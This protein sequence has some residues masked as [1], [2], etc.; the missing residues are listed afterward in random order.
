MKLVVVS[1]FVDPLSVGEPRWCYDLAKA[2][3]EAVDTVVI[4]QS[5]ARAGACV[6]DFLPKAEVFE[7]SAW[8]LR[9]VPMRLNALIKPNYVKFYGFAR[10]VIER[11]LDRQAIACAHQFG[12]LGLR[13]PSP[14]R[15]SGIPY[16]IGPV[17]G[18][19]QTPPGFSPR[20]KREPW[21]YKL[22]DVDGLRFRHDPW[23]R[24]TYANADVV[25]GT[26]DY[27]HDV[28][29]DIELRSFAT[30]SEIAAMPPPDDID[31]VLAARATQQGPLR[32]LVVSRLV[33]TKGVQFTL[34]ALAA[35]QGRL[36]DW[37]LDVLGDGVYR[38]EL[39]RLA[40][41]LGIAGRVRFHGHVKR[42]EVDG[43]YRAANVFLF[44]SVREPSGAVIF[45]AMS[46]GLPQIVADYGGPAAHVDATLGIRVPVDSPDA[47][48][49]RLADAIVALGSAPERR[50]AM[51]LAALDAARNRHGMPAMVRFFLG[52][53]EQI[54]RGT[55]SP[56]GG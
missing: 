42:V 43:Y 47:F 52:L 29:A 55:L 15:R 19:L 25:V 48:V 18:S 39:Q 12:P 7:D 11:R 8:Q 40:A 45:E 51:A 23:L 53:Y 16:V 9:R 1:P 24:S 32:F 17:G 26:G 20:S 46:W 49:V 28:L 41:G 5:P 14:L 34:R 3:S 4:A 50:A 30:R 37:Q 38:G 31:D 44:A 33:H 10:D 2:L 22:R 54:A 35:A 6:A 13:Y 21:Y 56:A 27:V 36:P